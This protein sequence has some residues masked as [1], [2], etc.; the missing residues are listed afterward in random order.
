[1]SL[2]MSVFILCALFIIVLLIFGSIYVMVSKYMQKESKKMDNY[3]YDLL[4]LRIVKTPFQFKKAVFY[5]E[6][7][8]TKFPPF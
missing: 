5:H 3:M 4:K 1:M 8:Y 6:T 7:F 2:G